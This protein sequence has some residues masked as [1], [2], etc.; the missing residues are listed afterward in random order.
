MK[1]IIHT[2]SRQIDEFIRT[3]DICFVGMADTDGTPYV[4]PMNFGY[5]NGHIYL[6]SGPEGRKLQILERNPRV[7]I[8]FC[9][10]HKLVWQHPDVAC[11]YSMSSR[12]LM[13]W[14]R[15][16]FEEDFDRKVELLRIFMR[17]YSD[18]DF[19]FSPPAV[20]NVR[21]WKVAIDEASLKVK[22]FGVSRKNYQPPED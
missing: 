20:N 22:E 1:T 18:R 13:V 16:E 9:R 11:S 17:Q 15:V 19:R 14:G 6:H 4:V 12:S 2:D 10:G 8:T 5:D 21:V 7:C 3:C